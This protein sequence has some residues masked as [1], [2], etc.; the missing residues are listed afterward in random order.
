ME[1]LIELFLEM[2]QP[3]SLAI[4]PSLLKLKSVSTFCILNPTVLPIHLSDR[5]YQLLTN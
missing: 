1:F 2:Y 3:Q 5:N 4:F